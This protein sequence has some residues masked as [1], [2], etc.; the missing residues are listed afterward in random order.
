MNRN[1]KP[2]PPMQLLTRKQAANFFQINLST[3]HHHTKS[4]K[5]KAVGLG[6]RVYYRLEDLIASLKPLN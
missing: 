6:N 2:I 1:D 4:G 5:I 3:L